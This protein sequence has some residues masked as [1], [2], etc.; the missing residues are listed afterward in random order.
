MQS[1]TPLF[2]RPPLL[3]VLV[4]N[5][6]VFPWRSKAHRPGVSPPP[7]WNSRDIPSPRGQGRD[8]ACH[9]GE[10]SALVG[11]G[12]FS[13]FAGS[14]GVVDTVFCSSSGAGTPETKQLS[15]A[16]STELV[17]ARVA[18]TA[19]PSCPAAT[20]ASPPYLF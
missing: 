6:K 2:P 11:T 10:A 1:H 4:L 3:P 15:S 5:A 20:N 9:R 16:E 7:L 13:W 18:A 8:Q 14:I 17:T 19:P 12:T